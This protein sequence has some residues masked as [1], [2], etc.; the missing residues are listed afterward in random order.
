MSFWYENL[1]LMCVTHVYFHLGSPFYL[2]MSKHDASR[3]TWYFHFVSCLLKL[4]YE[5]KFLDHG[6]I[7]ESKGTNDKEERR[8]RTSTFCCLI[9]N[10]FL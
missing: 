8:K 3:L 9:W 5:V 1:Q 4:L 2:Y 10:A 7:Y 6:T